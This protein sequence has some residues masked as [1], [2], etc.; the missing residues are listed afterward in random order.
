MQPAQTRL[1]GRPK[2][3]VLE[4]A[5]ESLG[6]ALAALD[7]DVE[8][9]EDYIIAARLLVTTALVSLDPDG[10]GVCVAGG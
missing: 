1:K 8:A 2:R 9:A 5:D 4:L 6:A 10:D 3:E 7:M